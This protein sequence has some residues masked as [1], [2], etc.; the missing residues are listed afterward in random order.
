MTGRLRTITRTW[1]VDAAGLGRLLIPRDDIVGEVAAGES[2]TRATMPVG[3]TQDDIAGEAVAVVGRF[4]LADGPFTSYR[5]TVSIPPRSGGN[6]GSLVAAREK[7]EYSLPPGGIWRVIIGAFIAHAL[8][9]PPKPGKTPI[10]ASAQRLDPRSLQVLMVLATLALVIGYHGT[11]LGQTITFATDE[12]GVDVDVQGDILAFARLGSPLA[13]VLGAIAD[14][15]GRRRMLVASLLG[16]IG[17]TV[18]GAIT[19]NLLG[20][21]VTQS[22]NRG[23]WGA[24]V[25]LVGV[26]LAEEMPAGARAHTLGLLGMCMALGAGLALAVLPVAD[27]GTDA[28]RLLYLFPLLMIP[29]VLRYGRQLPESKRYERPHRRLSLRGHVPVLLLVCVAAFMLNLI[30][31]PA[32]QF[33]NEFLRDERAFSAVALS[34]FA[35]LTALPGSLGILVGGRLAETM[36]RRSVVAV[37]ATVGSIMVALSFSTDGALMWVTAAVGTIGLAAVGPSFMIYY[38]ELFPTSLRGRASGIITMVAMGGSVVGL[39]TVG[40]LA[41]AFDAFGPAIG[42][43]AVGPCLMALIVLG[44]F[45]ETKLRELEDLNPEDDVEQ[46]PVTKPAPT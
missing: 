27:T 21:A 37:S 26:I 23:T 12:F 15:R 46:S 29:V 33:R 13:I 18:L 28:W 16:C 6:D 7:I 11:L 24:A 45:P 17:T 14:R 22:L 1:N 32:P 42:L 5:R 35:T 44:W 10:W 36:G 40:R 9:H 34:L 30:L 25:A 43:M 8:R 39:L 20:L 38:A 4:S 2:P 19:P 3:A 31:G 41:K